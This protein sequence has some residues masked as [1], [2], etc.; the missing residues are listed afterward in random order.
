MQTAYIF[1][2]EM[3]NNQTIRINEPLNISNKRII[4]TIQ[5]INDRNSSSNKKN[6]FFDLAGKIDIDGDAVNLLREGSII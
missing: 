2:A 6:K 3:I 5:P 4:V 1:E